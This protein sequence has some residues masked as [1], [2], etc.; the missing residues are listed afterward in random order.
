MTGVQTCALPISRQIERLRRLLLFAGKYVV[1]DCWRDVQGKP[2]K[3]LHFMNGMNIAGRVESHV[4]QLCAAIAS[5]TLAGQRGQLEVQK[6]WHN[7]DGDP[8]THTAAAAVLIAEVQA[9]VKTPVEVVRLQVQ[10]PINHG[11]L[12]DNFADHIGD[13]IE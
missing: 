11:R 7:L 8:A 5:D 2:R 10:L 9:F 1:V 13:V 12:I 3:R 6:L 4:S